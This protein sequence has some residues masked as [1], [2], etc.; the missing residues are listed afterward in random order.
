[1]M[2]AEDKS[3]FQDAFPMINGLMSSCSACFAKKNLVYWIVGII[4]ETVAKLCVENALETRCFEFQLLFLIFML[5]PSRRLLRAK[6]SEHATS[7]LIHQI[8]QVLSVVQAMGYRWSRAHLPALHPQPLHCPNLPRGRH[9]L[10]RPNLHRGL[11]HL[12]KGLRL[13]RKTRGRRR[14][15]HRSTLIRW[16]QREN[17]ERSFCKL[18]I[19]LL[20]W[21]I[22]FLC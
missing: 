5:Q 19:Q 7:A 1:M 3:W 11:L 13:K 22:E 8:H 10:H 17:K 15:I 12:S 18:C 20:V 6:K 16:P 14:R 4:V 21:E 9:P 2:L